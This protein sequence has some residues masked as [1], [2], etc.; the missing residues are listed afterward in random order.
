MSHSL[1]EVKKHPPFMSPAVK[2]Y[3]AIGSA[4]KMKCFFENQP[5]LEFK[6]CAPL[7]ADSNLYRIINQEQTKLTMSLL[8]G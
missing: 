5:K 6:Y 2:P 4:E 7:E 1:A 8:K 3:S